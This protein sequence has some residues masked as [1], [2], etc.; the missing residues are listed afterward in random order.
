MVPGL[1]VLNDLTDCK[2]KKLALI[3]LLLPTKGL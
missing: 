1:K 2:A 3:D